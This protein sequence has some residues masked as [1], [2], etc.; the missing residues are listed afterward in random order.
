MIRI[1]MKI[2]SPIIIK[3][4]NDKF[5]F[6]D[7]LMSELELTRPKSIYLRSTTRFNMLCIDYSNLVRKK[8]KLMMF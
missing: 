2:V 6:S 8:L 4:N 1:H 3:T 5:F 7:Y